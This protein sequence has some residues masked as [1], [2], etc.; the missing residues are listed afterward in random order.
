MGSENAG[1]QRGDA[2]RLSFLAPR[3][4][5]R[6]GQELAEEEGAGHRAQ[7]AQPWAQWTGRVVRGAP[8]PRCTSS[9]SVPAGFAPMR[10][11]RP[12]VDLLSRHGPVVRRRSV[13]KKTACRSPAQ[14]GSFSASSTIHLVALASSR[15]A[16]ARGMREF[17]FS[18]GN[19]PDGADASEA[20]ARRRSGVRAKSAGLRQTKKKQ[21]KR[22]SFQPWPGPAFRA[23]REV[24]QA[25]R[26][27]RFGRRKKHFSGER[28][29]AFP[30]N[31]T[32]VVADAAQTRLRAGEL[33]EFT[34]ASTRDHWGGRIVRSGFTLIE[35]VMIARRDFF[36]SSRGKRCLFGLPRL[37]ASP[38]HTKASPAFFSPGPN[39]P[40]KNRREKKAEGALAGLDAAFR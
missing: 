18:R 21:N 24:A 26:A 5:N 28:T 9:L 31:S 7:W 8:W 11:Y 12:S 38:H 32:F 14:E 30:Q 22:L 15:V 36:M 40:P 33:A 29:H 34:S 39:F 16:L 13:E 23:M 4:D 37:L 20:S 25:G 35:A 10:P 19:A 1:F 3:N 27:L 2:A 17:F 6:G